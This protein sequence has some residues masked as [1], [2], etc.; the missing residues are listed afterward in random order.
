ME[1]DPKISIHKIPAE[2]DFL[3]AYSVV[4][5]MKSD[6]GG[7]SSFFLSCPLTIVLTM[8]NVWTIYDES[9]MCGNGDG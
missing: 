4:P 9:Q 7:K 3:V 1:V 2:A 6:L 8:I 5:G